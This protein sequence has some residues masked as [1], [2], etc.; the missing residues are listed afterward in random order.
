MFLTLIELTPAIERNDRSKE[1]RGCLELELELPFD[2]EDFFKT[3]RKMKVGHV[4]SQELHTEQVIE[5]L[6]RL[7]D[8]YGSFSQYEAFFSSLPWSSSSGV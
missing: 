5:A 3:S 8:S 6:T 7:K 1:T 2:Q 4:I